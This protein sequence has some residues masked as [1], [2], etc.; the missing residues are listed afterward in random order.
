MIRGREH[1]GTLGSLEVL[2][3]RPRSISFEDVGAGSPV[4]LGHSFLCSGKMWCGQ[5]PA[6]AGKFRV[7][8]LD[9]RGHGRSGEVTRAFSLYDAVSDVVAVLDQ[10]GIKAFLWKLRR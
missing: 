1:R 9:F 5:V 8:N 3:D 2:E 6:L 4:V 10:L 7:L